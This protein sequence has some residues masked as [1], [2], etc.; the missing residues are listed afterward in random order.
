ML[1]TMTLKFRFKRQIDD[2][3]RAKNITENQYVS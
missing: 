2:E 3:K 1:D